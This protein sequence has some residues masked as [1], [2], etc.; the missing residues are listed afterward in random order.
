MSIL[1]PTA[2]I[3]RNFLE[4]LFCLNINLSPIQIDDKIRWYCMYIFI[5]DNVMIEMFCKHEFQ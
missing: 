4:A 3:F 2:N 1:L 5:S